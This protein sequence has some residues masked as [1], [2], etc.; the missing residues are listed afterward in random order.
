MA[1]TQNNF[2]RRAAFTSFGLL[3]AAATAYLAI[4]L[5]RVDT[6]WGAAK[7]VDRTIAA[8]DE[9]AVSAEQV[10]S[11]ARESLRYRPIDGRAYRVLAMQAHARGDVADYNRLLEIAVRRAPRDRIARAAMLDKAFFEGDYP[12][13]FENMDALF[14]DAPDFVAPIAEKIAPTLV[15]VE[16]RDA[17]EERLN[18]NPPWKDAFIQSIS[19]NPETAQFARELW[20]SGKDV[21]PTEGQLYDPGFERDIGSSPFE[22]QVPHIPGVEIRTESHR[23]LNGERSLRV[24]FQSRAVTLNAPSQA[25]TLNPGK[26]SITVL[27]RDETT[28][29]RPFAWVLRCDEPGNREEIMRVEFG[30]ASKQAS[31]TTVNHTFEIGQ[32]CKKQR[33]GLVLLS[34]NTAEAQLQGSLWTEIKNF[35]QLPN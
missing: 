34:R 20:A 7:G 19:K 1:T 21:T 28:S 32:V 23:A 30:K 25:V 3:F 18:S 14:R 29:R 24:N 9:G 6:Q 27:S 31:Q 35:S 16:I 26:Y 8:I 2:A 17:L 5:A 33:F 22:W 13:A 10:S 15:N 12:L 4:Q 11:M